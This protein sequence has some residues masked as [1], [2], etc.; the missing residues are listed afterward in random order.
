MHRWPYPAAEASKTV[1][2]GRSSPVY[3]GTS[4][5]ESCPPVALRFHS[6]AAEVDEGR[7]SLRDRTVEA[8]AG[9]APERSAIESE[10]CHG[11]GAMAPSLEPRGTT[12]SRQ[13]AASPRV[14]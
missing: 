9:R 10:A 4:Y 5:P 1:G 13:F 3:L 2:S 12:P 6:Q 8:S 14:P 7:E 11:N